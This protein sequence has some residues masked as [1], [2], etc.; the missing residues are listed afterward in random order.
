MIIVSA[1]LAG[2]NCKYDGGN[3]LDQTVVDLVMSGQ[4]VAICP[5]VMGGLPTPR[6]GAEGIL[7]LEG[8]PKVVTKDGRDVTAEFYEGA[9]KALQIAQ[10]IGAE[11]AILQPRS[12]SCGFGK[13]Y[14]GTFTRTLVDGMG[15]TA[16]ML[17][18]K[19]IPIFGDG[20]SYLAYKKEDK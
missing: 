11:A 6:V 7:D 9:E 1:C 3:N 2:I 10:I 12:P 8:K 16:Q 19:G 13:V 17:S 5:E 14:D 18:E 4:A 20:D 15:M